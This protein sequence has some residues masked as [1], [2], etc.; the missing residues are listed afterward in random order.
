MSHQERRRQA[1]TKL[2]ST[3]KE[4][5]DRGVDIDVNKLVALMGVDGIS[6]RTARDY[7]KSA[8]AVIDGNN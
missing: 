3:F 1:I 8:Q 5:K 2:I 6:S 4:A 7:I